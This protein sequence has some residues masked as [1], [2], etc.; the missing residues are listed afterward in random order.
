MSLITGRS[1]TGD[2]V[3]QPHRIEVTAKL[4]SLAVQNN[5]LELVGVRESQRAGAASSAEMTGDR[6]GRVAP[7]LSLRGLPAAPPY[8]S[9]HFDS[10]R[11]RIKGFIAVSVAYWRGSLQGKF[12]D[13]TCSLGFGCQGYRES[14]LAD[15][16]MSAGSGCAFHSTPVIQCCR[17]VCMWLAWE[18]F[19]ILFPGVSRDYPGLSHNREKVGISD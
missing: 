3:E 19:L 16:P 5:I 7:Q 11:E 6:A 4:L 12:S 17:H 18:P 1:T 2:A 14:D 8:C 15:N 13:G 10:C 9:G